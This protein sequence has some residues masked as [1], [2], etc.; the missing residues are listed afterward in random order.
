MKYIIKL[1]HEFKIGGEYF[2]GEVH[3]LCGD[4]WASNTIRIFAKRYN[5]RAKAEH[6]M[7]R[8]IRTCVNATNAEIE[9]VAE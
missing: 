5:T 8:L 9:E 2:D 6:T 4:K 3:K 1:N 7:N